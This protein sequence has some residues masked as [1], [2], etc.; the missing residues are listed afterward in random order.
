GGKP[1]PSPPVDIDVE[2]K[3]EVR[4]PGI[5]QQRKSA[6]PLLQDI[7]RGREVYDAFQRGHPDTACA[8][9][10][11]HDRLTTLPQ[12]RSGMHH[13][14]TGGMINKETLIDRTDPQ[15]SMAVLHEV[16]DIKFIFR[17]YPVENRCPHNLSIDPV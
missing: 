9:R 16:G 10:H 4:F 3:M 17:N 15:I 12:H 1:G 13:P 6:C 2:Y 5:I 7:E 14:S 11:R 8:M